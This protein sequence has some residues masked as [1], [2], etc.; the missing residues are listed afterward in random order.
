MT[1]YSEHTLFKKIYVSVRQFVTLR[2]IPNITTTSKSR[3]EIKMY[4]HCV[5]L[6]VPVTN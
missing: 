1:S 5:Q 3:V 2:I 6:E 4:K